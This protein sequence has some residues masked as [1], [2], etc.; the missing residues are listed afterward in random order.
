VIVSDSAINREPSH[1][2]TYVLTLAKTTTA[3]T[4]PNGDQGGPM[5]SGANYSGVMTIGGDLDEWMFVAASGF[6]YTNGDDQYS[7]VAG[8]RRLYADRY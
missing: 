8:N 5:L 3:I 2:S 4:V 7:L 1:A 6:R